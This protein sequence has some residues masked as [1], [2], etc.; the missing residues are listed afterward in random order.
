MKSTA[1]SRMAT[2]RNK[3]L[4]FIILAIGIILSLWLLDS[5]YVENGECAIITYY[6]PL[7]IY[8]K[9]MLFLTGCVFFSFFFL[10]RRGKNKF[11][12]LIVSML[13]LTYFITITIYANEI[14][15]SRTIYW[16]HEYHPKPIETSL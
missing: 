16:P 8:G 12:N 13:Y 7:G 10:L 4:P 3:V 1:N 2:L 11:L 15:E 5:R 9:L 6:I 14:L